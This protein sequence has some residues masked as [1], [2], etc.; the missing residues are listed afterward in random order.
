MIPIP[1]ISTL[2]IQAFAEVLA[3]LK[4]KS[5]TELAATGLLPVRYVHSYACTHTR[6][7]C[8]FRHSHEWPLSDIRSHPPIHAHLI[9]TLCIIS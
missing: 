6:F 7:T 2:S 3:T 5:L 9:C 1:V 4:L 8:M